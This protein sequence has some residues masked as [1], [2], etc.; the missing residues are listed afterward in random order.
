[1]RAAAAAAT[2]ILVPIVA[3]P[4]ATRTA[5]YVLGRLD[6]SGVRERIVRFLPT[7]HQARL[8]LSRDQLD[9]LAGLD[10]PV[11]PPIPNGVA[12]A[13]APLAGEA[14]TTY[15]P[16]SAVAAAYDALARLLKL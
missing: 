2:E 16:R 10:V 8:V 3:E 14:V 13:E 1:V 12:A 11:V 6:G 9:E 7:Q 15:A 5:E 4:M